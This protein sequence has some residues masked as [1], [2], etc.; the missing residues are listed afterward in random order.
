MLR[1]GAIWCFRPTWVC[2][3]LGEFDLTPSPY[4]IAESVISHDDHM[5]GRSKTAGSS[6]VGAWLAR[7]PLFLRSKNSSKY[8]PGRHRVGAETACNIGLG[9]KPTSRPVSEPEAQSSAYSSLPAKTSAGRASS[10]TSALDGPEASVPCA[11][12]A[13]S[14]TGYFGRWTNSSVSFATSSTTPAKS[15][16]ILPATKVCGGSAPFCQATRR[17][18]RP[19]PLR[20]KVPPLRLET[21]LDLTTCSRKSVTYNVALP[22]DD[23]ALG[24]GP[25]GAVSVS[26][27]AYWLRSS[28]YGGTDDSA[29]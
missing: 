22:S 24:E 4:R 20:T 13:I 19:R 12:F 21:G 6:R 29:R 25:S 15:P 5:C 26:P 27:P 10:P 8:N 28:A 16:S 14:Q 9:K 1:V 17:L 2:V 18:S 7:N 23:C 11:S 3:L